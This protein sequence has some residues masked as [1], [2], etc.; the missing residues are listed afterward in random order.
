MPNLNSYQFSLLFLLLKGYVISD[1]R[2]KRR[3]NTNINLMINNGSYTGI[4]HKLSLPVR[5]QRTRTNANT[6]RSKRVRN[7]RIR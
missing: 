2:I 6:Q 4:R 3:I 5:G 1:V 7:Q